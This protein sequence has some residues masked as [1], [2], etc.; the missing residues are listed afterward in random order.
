VEKYRVIF[1]LGEGNQ[2]RLG[3]TLGGMAGLL[4][5]LTSE[6]LEVELV[7]DAG[8]ITAFLKRNNLHTRQIQSLAARGVRFCLCARS[9]RQYRLTRE[10][11]L[12][13]VE[14]VSSGADELVTKQALGWAYISL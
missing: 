6:T 12:P 10:A 9:M 8:G 13:E 3:F 11:F 7:A 2:A 4:T 5:S 1:H 14:M